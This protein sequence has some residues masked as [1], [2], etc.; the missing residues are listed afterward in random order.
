MTDQE[1]GGI[2]QLYADCPDCGTPVS[3]WCDCPECRWYDDEAWERA[4]VDQ[5]PPDKRPQVD[6]G[7]ERDRD[8]GGA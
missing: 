6:W 4:L 3:V 2:E 1:N 5:L 7:I 8:G